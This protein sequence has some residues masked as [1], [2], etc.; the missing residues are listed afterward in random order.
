MLGGTML[1]D[2]ARSGARILIG[3]LLAIIALASVV[4]YA[5]RA[6]GPMTQD[7]ALQAE[8]LADVLPPP[9]F[10]VEPY[11]DASLIVHDP[12]RAG[13]FLNELRDQRAEFLERRAYWKTAPVP[14]QLRQPLNDTIAAADRFWQVMDSRFLPAVKSGNRVAMDEAFTMEIAPIYRVQ[15]EQVRS[16]VALSRS[17]RAD[18]ERRNARLTGLAL[19]SLASLALSML[20]LILWSA[21]A[22]QKLV[23]SPLVETAVTMQRMADGDTS[24][25]IDGL[26]RPDEIGQVARAMQV[27]RDAEEGRRKASAEQ[28]AVVGALSEG[29]SR[30]AAKDLEHQLSEPFPPAYERLRENYNAA[31]AS[32]AAALRIVR[33]GTASVQGSIAEIG[34]ASQDLALRNEAQAARI[35]ETA[36]AMDAVTGIVH[37]TAAGAQAVSSTITQAD[38]EAGE[39]GDVVRRAIEAMAAIERSAQEIGQII[40]VIDG[41]AFQT[42]L[43]ALNAG[44]EAARAGE[45]GKGFAVVATEVRA[46]AQ[47]SADAAQSIKALITTSGE[48]VGAGVELVRES[49]TRLEAIVR[50]INEISSLTGSIAGSATRQAANLTQIN[51]VMSEMDR[52]TQQNA[53]MVEESSAA[54]R[55]LAA[56]AVRLTDLVA[57][58]RTRDTAHRPA[59]LAAPD[60]VRRKS[61]AEGPPMLL[62]LALA[63]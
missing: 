52:M 49:G 56:E 27:F 18:T 61:A 46:L 15:R 45:A 53:A 47:R 40:S 37:E 55:S 20:A 34:A 30:L 24:V 42:N 32:L 23:V 9:A 12:D 41:I 63:S 6:D 5:I 26:E 48:Q 11:L 17:Y 29:L 60:A 51:S 35:A 62:P 58:F 28:A 8:I 19:A 4:V 43:L 36:R 57:T 33:I 54:T 1:S 59:A 16:I 25:A 50:R 39:G 2:K 31:V 21:R 38:R 14:D 44:V 13:S 3:L 7:S 22:A 10:V